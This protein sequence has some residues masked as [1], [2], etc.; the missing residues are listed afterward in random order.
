[1]QERSWALPGSLGQGV[2]F[3]RVIRHEPESALSCVR[4]PGGLRVSEDRVGRGAGGVSPAVQGRGAEV[5][6]VRACASAPAWEPL[7]ADPHGADRAPGSGPGD[8][9]AALPVPGVREAL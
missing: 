3:G 7:A 2:I 6:A 4:S 1:M 8:R 5:S 9:G